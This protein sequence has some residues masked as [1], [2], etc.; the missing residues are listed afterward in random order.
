[1]GRIVIA[2]GI[3]FLLMMLWLTN[4]KST[5]NSA[6]EV[7]FSMAAKEFRDAVNLAHLEWLRTAGAEQVTL[8][9]DWQDESTGLTLKM[10]KQGWPKLSS[11]N[12]SGCERIWLDLLDKP[13]SIV[14]EPILVYYREENKQTI[15]DY[16]VGDNIISYNAS[17]G[18]IEQK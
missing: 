2:V 18:F 8:Y 5:E 6:I 12:Q 4:F 9:S 7:S 15:C 1:M 16:L 10:N 14:K 17:S 3:M 11:L 13:L